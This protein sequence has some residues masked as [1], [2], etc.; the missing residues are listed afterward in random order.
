V[1][2]GGAVAAF[3]NGVALDWLLLERLALSL[4][5]LESSSFEVGIKGAS[6]TAERKSANRLCGGDAERGERC[7]KRKKVR[8]GIHGSKTGERGET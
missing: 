1:S 7:G 2:A 4:P 5:V 8:A 6:F 3:G